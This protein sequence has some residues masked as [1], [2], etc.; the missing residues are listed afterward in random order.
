MKVIF[1]G[2]PIELERGEGLSR[3]TTTLYGVVFPMSVEVDVSHLSEVQKRKLLNN[4]H[5]RAAG[6]DAPAVPLV[7]PASHV[8]APA[9]VDAQTDSGAE[10]ATTAR[11]RKSQK[12]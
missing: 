4:P 1:S 3:V 8:A 6:V 9:Q 10:I 7:L 11:P 2:D 5:F 12:A